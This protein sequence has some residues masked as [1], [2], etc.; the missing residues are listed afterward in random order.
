MRPNWWE[1]S[2]DPDPRCFFGPESN[3][4]RTLPEWEYLRRKSIYPSGF[5]LTIEPED[6]W[7]SAV[8]YAQLEEDLFAGPMRMGGAIKID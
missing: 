4:V 5:N 8:I 3:E 7:T 2:V 6:V 1:R